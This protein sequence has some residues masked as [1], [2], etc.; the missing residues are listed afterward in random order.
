MKNNADLLAFLKENQVVGTILE[1]RETVHSVAEASAAAGLPEENFIKTI[2]CIDEQT[3]KAFAFIVGGTDR[4]DLEKASQA[5]G[6]K[7]RMAKA[8]E[9]LEKTGYEVGGT[10]PVGTGIP[11]FVDEK[12]TEKNAVVG[13]GGSSRHLL[14]IAPYEIINAAGASVAELTEKHRI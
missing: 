8:K 14:K 9:A 11:V 2:I 7:V 4:L 5:C 6:Q 10:P 3:G 13:G 1:F 12:V